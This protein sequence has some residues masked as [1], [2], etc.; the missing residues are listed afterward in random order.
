MFVEFLYT[1]N[2]IACC[3]CLMAWKSIHACLT[4]ALI[5]LH[6][7]GVDFILANLSVVGPDVTDEVEDVYCSGLRRVQ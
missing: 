1:H 4:N 7:V 3:F 5:E 2:V 6:H